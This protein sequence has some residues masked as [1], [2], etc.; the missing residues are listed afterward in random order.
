ML[1]RFESY[2]KLLVSGAR[3]ILYRYLLVRAFFFYTPPLTCPSMCSSAA[4]DTN[5]FYQQNNNKTRTGEGRSSFWDFSRDQLVL[6]FAVLANL[7]IHQDTSE[8]I[9]DTHIN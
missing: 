3:V 7:K 4:L 1:N 9:L 8:R 6:D 2:T 5:S